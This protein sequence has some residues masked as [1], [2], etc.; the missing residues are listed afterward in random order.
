MD[1][2]VTAIADRNSQ[3]MLQGVALLDATAVDGLYYLRFLC[4]HPSL[5]RTGIGTSILEQLRTLGYCTALHVDF[6]PK[7][8]TLV[9]WYERHGY[10][11]V[12]SPLIVPLDKNQETLL[13]S[14]NTPQRILTKM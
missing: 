9:A 1:R 8:D 14:K 3:P 11:R 10:E 4:V 5:R 12:D 7:H 13:V 6:G 2:V